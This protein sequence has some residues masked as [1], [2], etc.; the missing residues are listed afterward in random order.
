MDPKRLISSLKIGKDYVDQIVH[1]EAI[2]ARPAAYAPD[3][4]ALSEPV[5][6]RLS[7]IGVERL[8]SHQAEAVEAVRAGRHVAVV[9]GTASGKTLCY[10]IPVLETLTRDPRAR[11]VYV[12]PTKALAQDQ[13]A[14]L[15]ELGLGDLF[16]PTTY[17]GDTPMHQRRD[18]RKM[19][20]IILTNPDMLHVGI[21]PHHTSWAEF[22]RRLR[23]VVIDEIH[24]Y[25]GVFG[26]HVGNV[27]RRLRRVCAAYGNSPQFICASATIP[28]PAEFTE[29]LTGLDF[30]VV[31][32]DGSPMAR[33]HFVLWNPPF[34]PPEMGRRSTNWES[35]SLFVRLVSEGTR[36]LCFTRARVTAELI[37]RYAKAELRK[38]S[39][40]LAKAVEPYRAGYTAEQ[41]RD[42]ERRFFAGDLLGISSTSALE[43]GV[44]VGGLDAVI[45]TGYPGSV[46]RTWQQVGRA[47][48]GSAESAAFMVAH[49]D[50]LDQFL[51]RHPDYLFTSPKERVVSDPGNVHILRSHMLC[52]AY[53][54]PIEEADFELFGQNLGP[55]LLEEEQS[56]ALVRRG[57]RWFLVSNESPASQVNVRCVSGKTFAIINNQTGEVLGTVDEAR[58]YETVHQGAV[59]LHQG[60]SY[61][62]ESLDIGNGIAHVKP[63][64]APFYTQP[65]TLDTTRVESVDQTKECGVGTVSLGNVRVTS[66]VV[67]YRRKQLLTDRAIHFIPL[68][69][70]ANEYTTRAIWITIPQAVADQLAEEAYDLPGSLHATEHCAIGLLPLVALCDRG[71]IGGVSHPRHPD[72][73][74]LPAV[75]IHDAYPGGVGIAE[76]A[77]ERIEDIL[78]SVI[79]TVQTC[80]CE[81]GCPSCVQ[82][83]KCGN[84]NQPLDKKGAGLLL[85]LFLGGGIEQKESDT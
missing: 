8:Y 61:L 29:M 5:A 79:S 63:L 72:L 75:F 76:V 23:Y 2:H 56:G 81:D 78:R 26:S 30:T 51:M 4:F 74:G 85:K 6:E 45:L 57:G 37:A 17:D 83:P 62:V 59:Y 84:N 52:A 80:P 44:D 9:T 65:T 46:T 11:A 58:A 40:G 21:L 10:N 39:A 73:G 42:I 49:D 69:M 43:L 70:P 15:R 7:R 66:K 18:I 54:L 34:F 14:K 67:G 22:F 28:N 27:L 71:D 41:R 13:L 32:D 36:T 12:F 48:R 16:S 55:L 38:V 33:K 1:V 35:A 68:D 3:S 47:G 64:R 53:E 20:R 50:P 60:E 19:S 77:Y 82:S 25:R 31:S 24:A